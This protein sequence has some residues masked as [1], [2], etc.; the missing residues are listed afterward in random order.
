VRRRPLAA[1]DGALVTGSQQVTYPVARRVLAA[2]IEG[3]KRKRVLAVIAAYQDE[4]HQPSVRE[5]ARRAKVKRGPH[6][7]LALI[8]R[9]ERD[10]LLRV[11]WAKPPARNRYEVVL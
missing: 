7:T 3:T 6:E 5:I 1:I 2:P 4:G 10:G 8:A 11:Q 9:L